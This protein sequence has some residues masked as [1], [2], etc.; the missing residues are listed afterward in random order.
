[1]IDRREFLGAAAIAAAGTLLPS[2]Y[3]FGQG[4][5]PSL[6][7]I[8]VAGLNEGMRKG[9]LTS[10]SITTWYMSR[11]TSEDRATNSMIEINP[12]ALSIAA[13]LDAERKSG[14]LRGPL[15]GI[16]VVLKDNIDT[17]DKMKTDPKARRV[18]G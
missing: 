7:E 14:K 18:P 9:S 6:E 4:E 13:Q 2:A 17:A 3:V 15:H 11:I 1:M 5:I 16:P 8:T 12:D 10:V